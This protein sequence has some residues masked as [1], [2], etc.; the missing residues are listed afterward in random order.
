[1]KRIFGWKSFT[2]VWRNVVRVLTRRRSWRKNRTQV[3]EK[4]ELA[5]GTRGAES[6]CAVGDASTEKIEKHEGRYGVSF[7]KTTGWRF[8]DEE[9]LTTEPIDAEIGVN[10]VKKSEILTESAL[11]ET[12][13][14]K[15]LS[16]GAQDVVDKEDTVG[17][18]EE[19]S[20]DND[21]VDGR[22]QDAAPLC[23]TDDAT[24]NDSAQLQFSQG[25]REWANDEGKIVVRAALEIELSARST[26]FAFFRSARGTLY[27][28]PLRRL[29]LV[30]RV[31]IDKTLGVNVEINAFVDAEV[32]DKKSVASAKVDAET[33][34]VASDKV[35]LE[36]PVAAS[37]VV[38]FESVDSE[39]TVAASESVDFESVDSEP[40]V[41]ASE[42]VDFESVDSELSVAASEAVDF[43][44]VDSEPSV[45]ASESV[46]FE[47]VD[48]ESSVAASES[49]DFESV[50]SESSVAASESVDFEAVD[51]EPSQTFLNQD[52]EEYDDEDLRLDFG[53]G[54]KDEALSLD[55]AKASEAEEY[56]ED[57]ETSDDLRLNF[58]EDWDDVSG[59]PTTENKSFD[60]RAELG[61]LNGLSGKEERKQPE[62]QGVENS[63]QGE[64]ARSRNEKE[65]GAR[66]K[67]E[68]K[69]K[70]ATPFD[71]EY[72]EPFSKM[73]PETLDGLL[74]DYFDDFD[75]IRDE[76]ETERVID[77]YDWTYGDA[78]YRDDE[79][80]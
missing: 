78:R 14:Q 13:T 63:T 36:P 43:E 45:A 17:A 37:E 6:L 27:R 9:K 66:R 28:Y 7:E 24:L 77:Y 44:S 56:A 49:V 55:V 34:G 53:A 2:R 54:G 10:G 47:S 76:I 69:R 15:T 40:P 39:P 5:D 67:K 60:G 75:A 30:D 21:E 46:D 38:D 12:N 70:N 73:E 72:Y 19:E 51:A 4:A 74:Y 18:E 65:N 3:V 71:A 26:E 35:D 32:E 11:D 68:K 62:R 22:K 23:S 48:S 79:R 64:K 41:A 57:D 52:V 1:M 25:I 20:V 80:E 8:G 16:D 61:K 31:W 59:A 29:S 50:D 33:L 58:W 42:V